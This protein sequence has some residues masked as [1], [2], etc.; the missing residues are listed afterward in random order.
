MKLKEAGGEQVYPAKELEEA[1]LVIFALIQR[2]AA[3]GENGE[4]SPGGSHISAVDAPDF[5]PT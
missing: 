3:G 1:V 5:L 4:R 2:L